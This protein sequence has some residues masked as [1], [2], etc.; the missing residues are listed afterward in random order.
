ML[1][2]RRS[3]IG[4][5]ALWIATAWP[6]ALGEPPADGRWE[7]VPELTDE[8]KRPRLDDAM[9]LD[10]YP[11]WDGRKPGYFSPKNVAVS[12]GK[13]QITARMEDLPGLPEGYHTFTTGAVRSKVAVKYGYFEIKCRPMR[14]KASSGFWFNEGSPGWWTE[15]DVFE[16]GPVGGQRERTIFTSGHV[17]RAPGLEKG[18]AKPGKWEAPFNLADDYHTHA[19]LWEKDMITFYVDGV[20]FRQMENTHW[21]N[22]SHLNLNSEIKQSWFGLPDK[23]ELPAT[24]SIE[25]VRSW[26]RVVE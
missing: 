17:F 5:L 8:F 1:T 4:A 9:W 13:L 10:H 3:L 22:P 15:I 11:K 23:E 25:Y 24:F 21:H 18:F 26:R 19:L 20:V 2:V 14:S 6:P 16:V 12:D 7:P